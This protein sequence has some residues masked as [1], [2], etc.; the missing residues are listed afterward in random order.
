[1][2]YM[3]MC[4]IGF[5]SFASFVNVIHKSCHVRPMSCQ[6]LCRGCEWTPAQT[7]S[8]LVDGPPPRRAHTHLAENIE[9]GEENEKK[10]GEGRE[11]QTL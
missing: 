7:A 11:E 5:E 10:Q 9:K 6:P 8:G 3:P 1:M 2:T 4:G